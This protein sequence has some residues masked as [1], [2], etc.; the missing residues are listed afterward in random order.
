M[1][2][3]PSRSPMPA[4]LGE[5]VS[6]IIHRRFAFNPAPCSLYSY[7]TVAQPVLVEVAS[8]LSLPSRRA[9]SDLNKIDNS[10]AKAG[11][12]AFECA[13]ERIGSGTPRVI[14]HAQLTRRQVDLV[15]SPLTRQPRECRDHRTGR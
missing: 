8:P 3:P 10:M 4:L 5:P 1:E 11:R 9:C 15:V 7:G 13:C 14:L 2:T 6:R 12:A